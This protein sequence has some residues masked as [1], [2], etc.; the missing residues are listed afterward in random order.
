MS[1]DKNLDIRKHG[2]HAVEED[3]GIKILKNG[4]WLHQGRPIKRLPLVKLF[5]TVLKID[6]KG[7]YWLQTPV[8]RGR[9]EV[10]DKPFLAVE[11]QVESSEK[12]QNLLFR[13]NLD[14]WVTVDAA[15]PL[16]FDD[17]PYVMVRDGLAARLNR[18]TYYALM[19]MAAP[20]A[21]DVK[22]YGVRSGGVFFP[23]ARIAADTKIKEQ[24]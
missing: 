8:E 5:A 9:I 6:E 16:L 11:M 17:T 4:T 20:A 14:D 22:A 3:F 23:V 15:H 24:E 19:E 21:G 13:T 12:G 18:A 2:F 10:E 7:D 1:D